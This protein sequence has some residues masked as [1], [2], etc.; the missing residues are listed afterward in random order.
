M[1]LNRGSIPLYYQ[2][3]ES[4][5]NMIVQGEYAPGDKL[6][7]EDELGKEFGVSRITV[8][9]ALSDLAREGL[10]E[11]ISGKGTTVLS[12]RL[13]RDL[14]Q[15]TSFSQE[16]DRRDM[17]P[18]NRLLRAEI[19]TAP[20]RIAS[21]FLMTGAEQRVFCLQRVRLVNNSPLMLEVAYLPDRTFPR[22]DEIDWNAEISL[23][24]VMSEM[25]HTR[26][27]EAREIVEP[28]LVT[29]EHAALL[30]VEPYS[31]ALH[32]E[33]QVFTQGSDVPVEFTNAIV[34]GQ[35]S[36]YYVNMKGPTFD[37]DDAP[38]TSPRSFVVVSPL[39]A[40]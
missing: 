11:R 33:T 18:S 3:R 14:G 21:A 39:L 32:L 40:N 12:Q 38:L 29:E 9:R 20:P 37:S 7:S 36:R 34:P 28:V 23:Y 10:L 15:L 5:R 35:R 6:P 13:E 17:K 8:R 25:Y 22:M 24:H 31:P 16:M 30:E 1:K 4:L 26:L 19:I 27:V 2:L